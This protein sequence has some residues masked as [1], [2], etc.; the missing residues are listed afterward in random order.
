MKE[1]TESTID[2]LRKKWTALLIKYTQDT[3]YIETAC[4][5]ILSHYTSHAR[6]YHNEFHI[7][8]MLNSAEYFRDFGVNFDQILFAVWFHDVIYNPLKTNNEEKSAKFASQI[9]KKIE[10][11]DAAMVSDMI[12]RTKNH[13]YRAP[14]ESPELKVLLDLDL[15]TMGSKPETYLI[16]TSNIRKEYHIYPDSIFKKGRTHVLK[17]FLDSDSIYR[18]EIFKEKYENQAFIN[19]SEELKHLVISTK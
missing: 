17:Q 15:E 16:N 1:P 13:F 5:K 7:L 11:A 9:L 6:H 4:D 12:L 19:I 2:I 10:Y 18:T 8:K 14:N 3:N